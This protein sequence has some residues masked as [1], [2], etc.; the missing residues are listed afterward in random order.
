MG[1]VVPSVKLEQSQNG[2]ALLLPSV[3]LKGAFSLRISN[4]TKPQLC[5]AVLILIR[6]GLMPPVTGNSIP[7]LTWDLTP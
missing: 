5:F 2:R 1:T 6:D 4:E 7:T 3:V